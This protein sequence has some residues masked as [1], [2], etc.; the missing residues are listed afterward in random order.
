MQFT[1]DLFKAR[2]SAGLPSSQPGEANGSGPGNSA[3]SFPTVDLSALVHIPEDDSFIR[4]SYR[5]VL[6]RDCDPGS[7][8]NCLEMLRRHTPRRVLL[9]Q[10]VQSEE[11]QRRGVSFKGL[12]QQPVP[13]PERRSP[14]ASLR[15]LAFKTYDFLRRAWHAPF[16]SLD[17]KLTL[18]LR[19]LSSRINEV[20]E[21]SDRSLWTLSEKLDACGVGINA[22]Q[23]HAANIADLLARIEK[24]TAAI[25]ERALL[26]TAQSESQ[27]AALN[28][29]TTGVS[30]I[31]AGIPPRGIS[32]A[33]ATWR[34]Q[35]V[36]H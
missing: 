36:H 8:V 1:K 17:Q 12:P 28:R 35:H 9:Q 21:T 5:R 13:P 10:M 6:N 23:Q 3:R 25:E 7:F 19:E 29:L 14:V 18:I 11:A 27:N 20:K 26:A 4:E 33:D 16:V 31:S 24:R 34:K 30:E 15:R 32:A 22:V 2:I